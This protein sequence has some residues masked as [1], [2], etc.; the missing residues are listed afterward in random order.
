MPEQ[1]SSTPTTPLGKTIHFPAVQFQNQ[2][3]PLAKTTI[4]TCV[5]R[6]TRIFVSKTATKGA[7]INQINAGN[8]NKK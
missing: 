3:N 7:E 5:K 6:N 8:K 4:V 1:A 2:E